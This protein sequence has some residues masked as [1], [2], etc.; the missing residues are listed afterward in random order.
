MRIEA[1]NPKKNPKFVVKMHTFKTFEHHL[2]FFLGLK[3]P[4]SVFSISRDQ[5]CL[6]FFVRDH[7]ESLILIL[8]IFSMR[9]I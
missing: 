6:S 8:I 2:N 7:F 4:K 9:E 5:I 3:Y 1:P